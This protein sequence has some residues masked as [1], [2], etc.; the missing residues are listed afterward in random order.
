MNAFLS[1]ELLALIVGALIPVQATAN[2]TLSKSLQGNIPYSALTLFTVAGVTA[3]TAILLTGAKVP[4]LKEFQGAPWWSYISG[5][6]MAGYVL[7][8]TFLI[9]RIGVGRAIAL[10]VTGQIAAAMLIDQFGLLNAPRFPLTSERILGAVLMVI[11]VFL[12]MRR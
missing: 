6:V 2:T 4:A 3:L 9:P 11:G 7:T 1:F 8:I 5:A 10:I 12:A